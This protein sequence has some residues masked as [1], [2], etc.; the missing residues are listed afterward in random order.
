MVLSTGA[1][2]IDG[3]A[4]RAVRTYRSARSSSHSHSQY[5][6]TIFSSLKAGLRISN[7]HCSTGIHGIHCKIFI[8]IFWSIVMKVH[9]LASWHT[10]HA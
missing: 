7:Y 8:S 1:L 9:H 4:C 10:L 5:T 3:S 6:V 2:A